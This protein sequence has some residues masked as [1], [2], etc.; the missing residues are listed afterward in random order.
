MFL[1]NKRVAKTE[2]RNVASTDM[3]LLVRE[4]RGE[5]HMGGN[6]FYL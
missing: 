5:I 2:K 6:K 4:G 3:L 1:K